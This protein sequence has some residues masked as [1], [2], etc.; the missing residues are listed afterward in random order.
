MNVLQGGGL[1]PAGNLICNRSTYDGCC[2]IFSVNCYSSV[3]KH[4][5]VQSAAN[6]QFL[7]QFSL[8]WLEMAFSTGLVVLYQGSFS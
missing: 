8:K 4:Y 2:G 5:F 3:V 6:V 1:A 7:L